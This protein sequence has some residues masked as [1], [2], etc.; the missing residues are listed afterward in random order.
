MLNVAMVNSSLEGVVATVLVKPDGTTVGT[1]ET[2]T[3]LFTKGT[4]PI[5]ESFQTF[6]MSRVAYM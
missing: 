1:P 2:I 6:V 5:G 3:A 4:C